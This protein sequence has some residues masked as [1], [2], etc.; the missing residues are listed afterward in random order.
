MAYFCG[1]LAAIILMAGSAVGVQDAV[2]PQHTVESITRVIGNESDAR[3]IFLK[4]YDL[5]FNT[6]DKRKRRELFLHSQIRPE[7]VPVLSQVD[8]VLTTETEAASLSECNFYR[9]VDRV[10]RSENT[11]TMELGE[12]CGGG[13][14]RY[15]A[16]FDD[17]EWHVGPSGL[18]SGIVGPP[19]GCPC[20]R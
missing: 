6:D 12:H 15:T 2:R 18:G 16:S 10:T 4:V 11:V 8:L 9:T 19:I 14:R 3:A 17:G 13:S 7:W 1:S 20:L 5:M